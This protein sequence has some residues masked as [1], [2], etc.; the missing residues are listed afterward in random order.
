MPTGI[1]V[2]T[3]IV[4]EETRR[5][6][7][8]ISKKRYLELNIREKFA[9]ASMKRKNEKHP[10]WKGDAVK[11]RALHQWVRKNKPKS[12][13]CEQCNQIKKLQLA[14]KIGIYNRQ[15]ENWLWLCPPCHYKLDEETHKRGNDKKRLTLAEKEESKRKRKEYHRIYDKLHKRKRY[16]K[17][18]VLKLIEMFK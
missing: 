10:L 3:K 1:Y 18:P 15:F 17:A 6:L 7:S 8:E 5:K 11:Y 12:I 2:R 9:E 13:T 4:T 14:N 16:P